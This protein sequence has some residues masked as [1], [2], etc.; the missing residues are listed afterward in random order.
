MQLDVCVCPVLLHVLKIA[1]PV[2]YPSLCSGA[3]GEVKEVPRCR[4]HKTTGKRSNAWPC[5]RKSNMIIKTPTLSSSR[6][7]WWSGNRT[8]P[9]STDQL[10]NLLTIASVSVSGVNTIAH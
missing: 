7:Q 5:Y 4:G 3:G 10:R 9:A 1:L 6:S 8:K 2:I